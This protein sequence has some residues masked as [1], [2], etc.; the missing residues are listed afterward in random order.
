MKKVG[1][2]FIFIAVFAGISAIVMLLWNALIPSII[3]WNTVNYWQAAGLLILCKLLL[4]GFG[5]MKPSGF[6]MMKEARNMENYPFSHMHERMGEMSREERREFILRRM[7]NME[8]DIDNRYNGTKRPDN[9][10]E[11]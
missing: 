9:D 6:H 5:R 2:L 7:K 4:G 3:G 10:I 8:K 1:G 11:P